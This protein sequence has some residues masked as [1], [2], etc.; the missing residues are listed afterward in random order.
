SSPGAATLRRSAASASRSR[1][2]K[3]AALAPRDR[4]S[5][6]K[7][8]VPAKPSSTGRSANGSPM[9]AKGPCERMLKR[10]SRARSLV[11][12]TASPAGATRRRPR[13]LPPTMRIAPCARIAGA[14][15]LQQ[16]LARH[17]LDR[18]LCQIA[19]LEWAIGEAD[20]PCHLVAEM[21]EDAPNLAVL[22]FLQGQRQPGVRALL[23]I[24]RRADR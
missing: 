12:R 5:R 7:A 13:W 2:M 23:A 17:L 9:A 3:A 11:G 19:Q 21:F 16:H 18:T 22:A 14:E 24:E 15:L 4:A 10:A 8:P 1:S 6:P 20:E